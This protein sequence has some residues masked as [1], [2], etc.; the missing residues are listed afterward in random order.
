MNDDEIKTI[1]YDINE[2]LIGIINNVLNN[3]IPHLINVI[4]VKENIDKSDL[5]QIVDRFNQNYLNNTNENQ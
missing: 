3:Q 2:T 5:V 4:S 1:S